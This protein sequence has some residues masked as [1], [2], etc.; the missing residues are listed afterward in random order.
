MKTVKIKFNTLI[1]K[2]YHYSDILAFFNI[3]RI[4]RDIPILGF[5]RIIPINI[6]DPDIPCRTCTVPYLTV[7][8]RTVLIVI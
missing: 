3:P 1:V 8:Y 4:S 2:I 5:Y 6:P 7:P